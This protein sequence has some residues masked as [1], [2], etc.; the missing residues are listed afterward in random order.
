MSLDVYLKSRQ[1]EP[2]VVTGVIYIR[3]AGETRRITRA[4]WNRRYPG[5]E[6]VTVTIDDA[7]VLYE[8]NITHN[9][10]KMAYEAGLYEVIWEPNEH[11]INKARQLIEPIQS[12]LNALIAE[13]YHYQQFN[14]PNGWGSYNMFVPWVKRYLDACRA[15]PDADVS[16]SR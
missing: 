6:P 15:N 13:P 12:G 14:P 4:E 11:G 2:N 7:G 3:E 1:T 5:R 9:L 16:V 10:A 8:A